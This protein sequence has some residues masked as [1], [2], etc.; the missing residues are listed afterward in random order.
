MNSAE[1]MKYINI[2]SRFHEEYII[3]RCE[4]KIRVPYEIR[5]VKSIT[6]SLVTSRIFY[7]IYCIYCHR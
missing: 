3:D 4:Y 2:D 7:G 1:K 5:D 6:I